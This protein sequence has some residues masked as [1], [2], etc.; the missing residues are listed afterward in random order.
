MLCRWHGANQTSVFCYPADVTVRVCAA[1]HLA[2]AA[3]HTSKHLHDAKF[4]LFAACMVRSDARGAQ[5]RFCI[6]MLACQ[7]APSL[8]FNGDYF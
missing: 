7:F 6:P 2:H 4:S 1:P 8:L 3:Q 5:Q